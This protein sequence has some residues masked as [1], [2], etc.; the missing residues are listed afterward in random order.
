MPRMT[1]SE[2][3]NL[4]DSEER[5][6][7]GGGEGGE[8]QSRR[9]KNIRLYKH[10][11][12]GDETDGRSQVRMNVV[13]ETVDNILP[14]LL[15][16]FASRDNSVMFDPIGPEDIEA[17]KQETRAVHHVFWQKLPF[18]AEMFEFKIALR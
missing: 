17:A 5:A 4:L 18:F 9:S 6:A 14:S 13:A 15:R 12:L 3:A 1:D 8:L 7:L 16:I 11:F 2:L 10:E